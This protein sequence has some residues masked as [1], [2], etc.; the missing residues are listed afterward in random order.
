MFS[1]N[2]SQGVTFIEVLIAI[3]IIAVISTIAIPA[4]TNYIEDNR[5]RSASETLYEK[6]VYARSEAIKRQAAITTVFQTGA[7]WCYGFTTS[8]SCD[9]SVAADCG[10]GQ[11]SSS[12]Y[13]DI[14]LSASGISSST[15]FSATRGIVSTTGSL[16]FSSGSGD[17]VTVE[18]NKLGFPKICSST[19]SG[20]QSC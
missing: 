4:Y 6:F 1:P 8:S 18:L 20:Y 11:I 10:L 13:H 14:S 12:N 17:V 3:M 7:T 5:L 16:S 15:S 9:C 19:M 2:Q